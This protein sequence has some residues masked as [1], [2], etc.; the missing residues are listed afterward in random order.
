MK[1]KITEIELARGLSILCVVLIHSTSNS[2]IEVSTISLIYPVYLILNR[3]ACFAVPA[4]IFFSGIVLFYRYLDKWSYHQ[5]ATFYLQRIKYVV[6][7][8]FIWAVMYYLFY[9]FIEPGNGVFSL[10][11]LMKQVVLGRTFYHLYF[12]VLIIQYY[13]LT[14]VL[15]SIAKANRGAITY[16]F[17]FSV[18]VQAVMSLFNERYKWVGD[19][20]FLF[21]TYFSSFTL[22]CWIGKYYKTVIERLRSYRHKLYLL[23]TL[24]A[25]LYVL[26]Q[27][28]DVYGSFSINP[29]I[30]E[31]IV[32]SYCIGIAL[33][34]LCFFRSREGL[35]F[36]SINL[37]GT[38]GMCSFGIYLLHPVF[39]ILFEKLVHF[40][41]SIFYHLGVAIKFFVTCA[42]S[43]IIFSLIKSWRWAWILTGISLNKQKRTLDQ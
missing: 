31:L 35:F 23:S 8:Y 26:I 14:P 24:L 36:P 32:H 34:L 27:I 38:A 43:I 20:S 2:L 22:G 21:T 16:L 7:P 25:S 3:L 17:I 4:F 11:D 19:K 39:I 1:D 33:S 13:V 28:N 5:S 42:A 9:S 15:L 18:I 6:I 10:S 40:P 30:K 12:A 29:L 41:G 37:L